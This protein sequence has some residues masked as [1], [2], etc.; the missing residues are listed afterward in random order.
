MHQHG[1]TRITRSVL[2]SGLR[3]I[4]EPMPHLR[5]VALGVWVGVGSVDEPESLAGA[6]HYLEHWLFRR[7]HKRTGAE[8]N[9][10]IDG[11]GGL[12]N[13]FTSKEFT[14]YYARALDDDLDLASEV[15]G[16]SVTEPSLTSADFEAER[17]VIGEEL[18]MAGDDPADAVH[19][20]FAEALFGEHPL[21]RPIL[22][23]EQSVASLSRNQVAGWF[24]RRYTPPRIVVTAVGNVDHG[25]VVAQV[26]RHLANLL[27]RH[28]DADPEPPRQVSRKR[29][30][31]GTE[32]RDPLI[33][34]RPTE[35]AHVLVG[36]P[37]LPRVHTERMPLSVVNAVLGG[38]LSSR[39][40]A[41]IREARGLAYS[42]FSYTNSFVD[43]GSV[44]VYAGCQPERVVEVVDRMRGHID[45]VARNGITE[46]EL[47]LAKGSLRGSLVL[48]A[49]DP[50]S[51]MMRLGKAELVYPDYRCTDELLAGV[52]DVTLERA[53]AV[54]A[55][56]LGQAPVLA[57]VG[58]FRNRR[59]IA[60]AHRRPRE[61]GSR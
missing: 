33:E 3:V 57:A 2:P 36:M 48:G 43:S 8:I 49:E 58:P 15:P 34:R 38:G 1:D 29:L 22:G 51:R 28:D 55:Q 45:D 11:A 6:T 39:L 4:T 35:Q 14:C 16:Y 50:G 27:E 53:N 10:L 44:G 60:G 61:E 20:L 25:R 13:A 46:A 24:R 31:A 26:R 17:Q 9:K 7:T 41:D 5:S 12:L 42:V 18:A 23:T 52:D 56:V 54:A 37:G 30:P 21:A 40:F 59:S 19:E 47:D 32:L